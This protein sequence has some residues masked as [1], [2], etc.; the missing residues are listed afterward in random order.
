MSKFYDEDYYQHGLETGKS[1]YQ[2]YRWMPELTMSLAMTIIDYLNINKRH[3]VLDFGCAMGYLVKAFRLLHRKAW[4]IDISEYAIENADPLIKQYC[5]FAHNTDGMPKRFDFCIAKDVL[6]HIPEQHLAKAMKSFCANEIFVI[7]P[8][9]KDGVFNAPANGL[10]KSHVICQ[11]MNWWN[12]LFLQEGWVVVEKTYRV[13]G[14]K[15]AYYKE[16]PEA[17][18]FFVLT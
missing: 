2:N 1:N 4:G 5:H 16:F 3:T 12:R 11:D 6:E 14:I 10:D 15:D 17:H 7:V 9:G 18:G 13:D 8:L